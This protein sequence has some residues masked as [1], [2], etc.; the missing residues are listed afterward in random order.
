M[1]KLLITDSVSGRSFTRVRRLFYSTFSNTNSSSSSRLDSR[2]KAFVD[3]LKKWEQQIKAL[4][5]R[6]LSIPNPPLANSCS[7][8]LFPSRVSWYSRP[9][10][11]EIQTLNLGVH[12]RI[13]K[14]V[15]VLNP[16]ARLLIA[17]TFGL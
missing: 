15:L 3:Q 8:Y 17:A 6:L 4:D 10:Y 5:V 14:Y 16:L 2:I 12:L 9:N 11:H 13:Y 7:P 1:A